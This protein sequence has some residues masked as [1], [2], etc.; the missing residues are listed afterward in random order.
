[1]YCYV[2]SFLDEGVW[3]LLEG[4]GE[5]YIFN[6]YIGRQLMNIFTL[7]QYRIKEKILIKTIDSNYVRRVLIQGL[8]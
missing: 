2:Q 3:L 4:G 8:K 5:F 1:M 7:I 6:F